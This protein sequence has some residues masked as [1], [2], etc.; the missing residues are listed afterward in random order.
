MTVCIATVCNE[1]MII[2]ASDRMLTSGDIQFEPTASKTI[3]ITSSIAVMQSGDASFQGEIISEV[4]REVAALTKD[5][6][7]WLP[8]QTVVDLYVKHRNAAKLKRAEAKVLQ[9]L[10][11]TSETYLQ[12]ASTLP[13]GL[14]E[15]IAED[16]IN[17]DVPHVSVI[18]AGVDDS[19]PRIFMVEEGVATCH[20]A[21]GFAAIGIGARHAESH[22]MLSR[23]SWM[24]SAPE[25][26]VNTYIA[27][28]RAETAPGVGAETDLFL[29]G[30]QPGKF[31]EV[32]L[33]IQSKL[34]D[35]YVRMRTG[36]AKLQKS[37]IDKVDSYVESIARSK[38]PDPS[39]Q[40]DAKSPSSQSQS[41][42]PEGKK[43]DKG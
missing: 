3:A 12:R 16:L 34:K 1:G 21:I 24:V 29:L 9:P 8:V 2:M 25:T 14:V 36:E 43:P 28:R 27:K 10:G 23:H 20:D 18:V 22:L 13:S 38:A 7:T 11:L 19:G 15:R 5:L 41:G 33:D 42:E 37:I 32:R 6:D 4:R 35:E 26:L 17:F 31:D 40:G 39:D 30:S